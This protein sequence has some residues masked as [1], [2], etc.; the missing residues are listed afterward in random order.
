[1]SRKRNILG[2]VRVGRGNHISCTAQKPCQC[3]PDAKPKIITK[4]T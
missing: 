3:Q 1:M 4:K 2:R